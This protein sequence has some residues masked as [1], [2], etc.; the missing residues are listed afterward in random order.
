MSDLSCPKCGAT[1]FVPLKATFVYRKDWLGRWRKV[2]VADVA[3]CE[4]C[5][6]VWKIQE[7]G[8]VMMV[9]DA[10]PPPKPQLVP[11][12]DEDDEDDVPRHALADAVRRPEV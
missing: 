8:A 2:R 5:R 3:G 7:S 1:H 11:R 12:D 6:R 9:E 4:T 10:P